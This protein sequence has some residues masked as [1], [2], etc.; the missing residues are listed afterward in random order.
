MTNQASPANFTKYV[1]TFGIIW[2]SD[3]STVLASGVAMEPK[4]LNPKLLVGE[5]QRE[6]TMI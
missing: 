1:V 5:A 3:I 2:L 6:S 4:L